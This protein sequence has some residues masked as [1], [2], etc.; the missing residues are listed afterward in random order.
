[1]RTEKEGEREREK[2][3]RE[4]FRG[5]GLEDVERC[6]PGSATLFHC[7]LDVLFGLF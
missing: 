5:G 1:M 6:Y 2:E 3:K 7:S 4:S